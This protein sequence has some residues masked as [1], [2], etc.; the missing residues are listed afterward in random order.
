MPVATS[1]PTEGE[2]VPDGDTRKGANMN[3]RLRKRSWKFVRFFAVLS[4]ALLVFTGVKTYAQVHG[5]PSGSF[6]HLG[7]GS[8]GLHG[9]AVGHWGLQQHGFP[10]GGGHRS[11]WSPAWGHG[12]FGYAP[13]GSLHSSGAWFYA[14][15]PGPYPLYV[16]PRGHRPRYY[17]RGYH[18]PRYYGGWHSHYYGHH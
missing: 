3:P 5:S 2:G 6:G 11:N 8:A 16:Y 7:Q 14:H 4:A 18:R 1:V 13:S 15:P 9:A 10:Y 12:R 17:V